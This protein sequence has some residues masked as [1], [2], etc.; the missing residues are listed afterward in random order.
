M[1]ATRRRTEPDPV[2]PRRRARRAV[3]IA[4]AAILALIVG[5][6]VYWVLARADAVPPPPT[7]T[8]G[9]TAAAARPATPESAAAPGGIRTPDGCLGGPDPFKAILPAQQ[10]ATLDPIG[11]AEFALTFMRWADTYPGDPNALTVLPK[12]VTPGFQPVILAGLNSGWQGFKR[13]GYTHSGS[14]PGAQ[15]QY[16]IVAADPSGVSVSVGLLMYGQSQKATGETSQPQM[17]VTVILDAVDGHWVVAGNG[18][19]ES[20]TFDPIQG[21]PWIPFAGVC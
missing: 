4:L 20:N 5:T 12:V 14:V 13:G 21:A 18:P 3:L 8:V 7:I 16:R 9:S 2:A 10:A 17:T 11:A 6:S 1:P 15:D 19:R